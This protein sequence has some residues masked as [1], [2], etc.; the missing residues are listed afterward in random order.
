MKRISIF[1]SSIALS[2][3]ALLGT[4]CSFNTDDSGDLGQFWHLISVD[5]IATGGSCD[6]AQRGIY[7][8]AEGTIFQ[9]G[10]YD[11]NQNSKYIFQYTSSDGRLLLS[12]PRLN[13]RRQ[14]DPSITDVTVLQPYGINA[15]EESFAIESVS[16]GKMML[17]SDVLRLHFRAQ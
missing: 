17:A 13:D 10:I 15:L 6:V 12:D 8:M 16:G 5:T 7:W 4:S 14:N 2:A 3:A 1:L 9:V 11:G